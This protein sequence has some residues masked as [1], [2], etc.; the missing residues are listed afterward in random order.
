MKSRAMDR[1]RAVAGILVIVDR[2]SA[3]RDR[4]Q[5]QRTGSL[6]GEPFAEHA[7]EA[8]VDILGCHAGIVD[9]RA[10]DAGDQRLESSASQA[11]ER[12]CAPSR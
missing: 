9:R 3:V 2:R 7:D 6:R 1:G 5:H 4:L 12:G 10:R 8:G 11:A